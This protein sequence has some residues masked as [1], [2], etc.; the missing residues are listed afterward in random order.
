[1]ADPKGTP[2]EEYKNLQRELEKSRK[3]KQELQK[4]LL[5]QGDLRAS[6]ARLEEYIIA[7]P[8]DDDDANDRVVEFQGRKVKDTAEHKAYAAIIDWMDENEAE[9]TDP[10]LDRV[11]EIHSAEDYTGVMTAIT[12]LG[13][14]G[15]V[16]SDVEARIAAEVQKA[17]RSRG[18]GDTSDGAGSSIF[19]TTYAEAEERLK[20]NSPAGRTWWK[21]NKVALM[22]EVQTG[23]LK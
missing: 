10:R 14:G 16:D 20:D 13:S 23:K 7:E 17:L 18:L 5:E 19:P 21:E 8:P 2:S 9:W 3:E 1:M 4:Q 15:N 12:N 11:R 6:I 22:S